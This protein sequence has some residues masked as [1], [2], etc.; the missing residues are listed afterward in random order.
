MAVSVNR[1]RSDRSGESLLH[2]GVSSCERV[3]PPPLMLPDA[4]CRAPDSESFSEVFSSPASIDSMASGLV[5][6]R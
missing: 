2:V 6:F 4:A 1:K 3:S 5:S